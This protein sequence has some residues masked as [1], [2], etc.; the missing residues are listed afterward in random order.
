MVTDLSDLSDLSG[1]EIENSDAPFMQRLDFL[2]R[3]R[4]GADKMGRDDGVLGVEE[5]GVENA[6]LEEENI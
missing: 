4:V 2:N 3:K 5:E 6:V 1:E